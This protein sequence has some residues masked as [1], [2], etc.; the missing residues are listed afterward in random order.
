MADSVAAHR[1][2]Y[3]IL[4]FLAAPAVS[5]AQTQESV[6]ASLWKMSLAELMQIRVVETGSLTETSRAKIPAAVTRI[7]QA[8][9][10][11]L[12]AR[13][14]LELLEM[15]VPGLQ[16]IRHFFDVPHIGLRGITSDREDKV[17]I[18]VNG[19]V[20]NER[21]ARG[22][23]TE[24]DFPL[25]KDIEHIDV[26]RGAGSSMYGLGAVATVIDITTFDAFTSN[27][28]SVSIRGGAGMAFYAVDANFSKLFEN[29]IGVYFNAELADVRGADDDDSPLIHGIDAISKATGETIQRGE[30][31]PTISR[32][33]EAFEGKTFVKAHLGIDYKDTKAWLRYTRG[34]RDSATVFFWQ[35]LPPVG[36]SEPEE[37]LSKVGYEQVTATLQQTHTL[38]DGFSVDWMFSFDQTDVVKIEPN[39]S[40]NIADY[41]ED[42][43]F[44]RLVANWRASENSDLAVGLEFAYEEFG[45]RRQDK[46]AWYTKTGSVIGEWQWRP[47]PFWTLFLGGRIDTHTYTDVMY[48][49]RVSMVYSND[50]INVFKFLM[51]KS[52]RMKTS[53]Q[54]RDEELQGS[55]GSRPEVLKSIEARYER[56]TDEASLGLSAYYIDLDSLGWDQANSRTTLLGTQTQWG[57]EAEW[58]I[59]TG[60]HRLNI[61]QAYTKLIDFKLLQPNTLTFVTAKPYGF[62]DDLAD[63]GTHTSKIWYT[64]FLNEQVSFISTLRA[65]WGFDGSRDFRDFR[66]A[67]HR[68]RFVSP[69]WEKGY[70][71]QVFLNFGM[72]YKLKDR[73]TLAV[74]LHNVLGV[75]DKDL[76]K[77]SYRDSYG[78]YRSEAVAVSL[79]LNIDF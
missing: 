19:R 62:G 50:D 1:V 68:D 76:N 29:D 54:L 55:S 11:E 21:T 2:S 37:Q 46:A 9:I 42:E 56:T 10:Q 6:A 61:S 36:G 64:Y 13:S 44:S 3:C 58:S 77:R 51:T 12:G 34:G 14:L 25:M 17:M 53:A 73:F 59:Q 30:A 40:A 35:A 71:E 78:G 63:W 24:R 60:S 39:P 72:R 66:V 4:C 18:R 52:Q 27:K 26:I 5:I 69:D 41:G 32:D 23:I 67:T 7:H 79:G 74:D 70:Q 20:M 43:W 31:F 16:V 49:P 75:F 65:I 8:E 45:L 48:S 15:T 47:H 38:W 28:N 57:L 22:A 33:G